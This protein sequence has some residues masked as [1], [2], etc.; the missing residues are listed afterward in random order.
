M[1]HVEPTKGART[2]TMGRRKP[3]APSSDFQI[4]EGAR[5]GGLERP[6]R[7]LSLLASSSVA[8]LV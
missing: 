3:D 7:L 4:D 8:D 5:I 2:L 1:V 6:A